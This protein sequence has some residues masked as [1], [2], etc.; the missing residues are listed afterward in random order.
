MAVKRTTKRGKRATKRTNAKKA[1]EINLSAIKARKGE[2]LTKG[3]GW[4]L[5]AT[6]GRNRVFAA[7]LVAVIRS[8]G[9]RLA[10]FNVPT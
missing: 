3:A 4:R 6:K 5:V 1:N 8:K 7:R 10:V 9:Q 2:N